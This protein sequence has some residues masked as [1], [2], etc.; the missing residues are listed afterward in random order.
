MYLDLLQDL[1]K[2][3]FSRLAYAL[4]AF[5]GIDEHEEKL[6]YAAVAEMGLDELDVA[7]AV[8]IALEC[9]AFGSLSSKRIALIELMLLALADGDLEHEEQSLL[10]TIILAFE[11][12]EQTLTEA[13]QW[14]SA[15]F[16]TYRAGKDFV[17]LGMVSAVS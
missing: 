8:D 5:H 3:A 16:Q 4:I 11:F 13:W 2:V 12:D 10:D 1:E 15:W 7:D 17:Q 6:F 9:S 14:V